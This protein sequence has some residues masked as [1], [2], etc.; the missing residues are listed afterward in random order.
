MRLLNRRSSRGLP[1]FPRG[2]VLEAAFRDR[3]TQPTGVAAWLSPG[4]RADLL[5]RY[6]PGNRQIAE[7]YRLGASLFQEPLP[8][9]RDPWVPPR[10]L[11][12]ERLVELDAHVRSLATANQRPK[13]MFWVISPHALPHDEARAADLFGSVAGHPDL[14][15]RIV[16]HITPRMVLVRPTVVVLIGPPQN[17]WDRFYLEV[18]RWSG[19]RVVFT[20]GTTRDSTLLGDMLRS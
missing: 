2:H 8:H 1:V 16:S 19:T 11:L 14:E 12:L 5:T 15:H 17:C 3:G 9:E 4:E 7:R 18:L 10:P 20:R 13:R 6:E